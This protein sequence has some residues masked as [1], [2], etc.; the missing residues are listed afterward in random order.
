MNKTLK[1]IFSLVL[2][3]ALI[4]ALVLAADG[5]AQKR[6]DAAAAQR[7]LERYNLVLSAS[8][9]APVEAD[10]SAYPGISEIVRAEDGSGWVI[11]TLTRGA[12]SDIT[13]L[14][15]IGPDGLCTGISVISHGETEGLGAVA[16]D[17]GEEGTAFRAQF[18]GADEAVA[19]IADGGEIDAVTG[20]T[21]T[22][23][24]ITEAVAEAVA[25][26]K[27]LG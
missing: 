22:S 1:N 10:L 3:L 27:T 24:A 16:A 13:M 2:T 4:S 5:A 21:I 26:V 19:L 11:T 6:I 15:G 20:A 9:F 14:T 23:R 18:T 12:K 17:P 7:A 25:A 8:S